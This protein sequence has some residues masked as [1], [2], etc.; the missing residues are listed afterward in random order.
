MIHPINY[1]P[2]IRVIKLQEQILCLA[3]YFINATIDKVY[4]N[5][6]QFFNWYQSFTVL[7]QSKGSVTQE[8]YILLNNMKV[9]N[10]T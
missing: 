7:V 4:I 8:K 2:I 1:N 10:D 5:G 6:K 3:P 9:S